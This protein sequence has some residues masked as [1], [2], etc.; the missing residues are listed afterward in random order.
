M[1]FQPG[2]ILL[3]K[4]RIDRFIGAGAF[5][6][7][8]QATHL[9][10]NAVYA[11]KVLRRDGPGLGSSEYGRWVER[12]RQEAK[13]G[14]SLKSAHIVQVYD[15]EEED[16]LLVLRM[17]YLPGGSLA[18]RLSRLKDQGQQLAVE[19]AVRITL[20]VAQGLA[21]LHD[22]DV[23]HRDVK[24]SNILFA[25]D[26]R[27]L[28]ADLGLAQMP[29]G[30]SDRHLL[31]AVDVAS[32]P[33]TPE[34]KSP[35]QVA[36]VDHLTS[37]S[38]VYT[39]GVVLFE[40][41]TGRLYRNVR[42]GT[43]VQALRPD[44]SDW[45]AELL[46]RMLA[47]DYKARSWDGNEVAEALRTGLA[48]ESR[49]QEQKAARHA[50]RERQ[51]RAAEEEAQQAAA[52][53]AEAQKAEAEQRQY[54]AAAARV[55][56][57]QAADRARVA[58]PVR[59]RWPLWAALALV[60]VVGV[61]LVRYLP[62]GTGAAMPTP[63]ETAVV[64]VVTEPP[65]AMA[66]KATTASLSASA[67]TASGMIEA[68]SGQ[69][70]KMVL[71]PKFLGILPF[72]E[73]HQGAE[74]A[75]K[76]L[77]NPTKLEYL[78]PT[79]ENMVAGQIEIV[80]TATTQGVGAVMLNNNAGD[81]IAPAAQAALDKGVTVV[82]WY[83]PIPSGEGE[84][85]FVAQV[86]FNDMGK[87]MADMALDILGADGGKFVVL[88]ASPDAANQNAWIAAMKEALKDP[89][90]AKLQLVDTVYGNDQSEESYKQAL[91]LI[92]K[93]P[94]LKL[95]MA[96]T[97]VGIVAAAKAM[98]DEGLCDTV[99]V[100]GLGLPSEMA[101]YIKAGCAPEI[102][103]WSFVDL[104]YLTYYVS[105]LIATG[106][107]EAKEGVTFKAGRM[108]EYTIEKDPTRANG[109]RVLMGPFTI[110]NKDNIDAAVGP[111]TGEAKVIKAEPGKATKMVLL[112][113]FLGI[114]A[115]DQAHQGAEEAA[116]ELGNPTKLE[117]LG[118][119]PENSVAGQIEIVTNATTQGAQAIMISN[120]AGDQIVPSV[121]A[122]RD[123][124]VS[125]VTWDSP[126]PSGEGEQV[127]VAQVDF[128][129]M[130][131]TMA[132]MA[133]DIMGPDGGNFAVL[134]A[135]PDAANQNAWIAAMK[136]ALKDPKY[137]KLKLIMAPTSV[138]IVA[139][140]KAMQDEGLCDKVK[141]SGL[142]LPSEM[143]LYIKAG[144]APEIALWSF[145]DLGYLTYYVS[146]LIANGQLKGEV[147]ERFEAGRMGTYTIEK[148]P[149]RANGLRVLMGPFRIYNKDN[150]DA[151]SK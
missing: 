94:D 134:S 116:K 79:T 104:G 50:E 62:P 85:V 114:L 13:L 74:E 115:F 1:L 109:L 112:P 96:P 106:Q 43:T 136:E 132:D 36:S 81:Q 16:D 117:F 71:L 69:A 72:D 102:A 77:G 148:D 59:Q 118:P 31:S 127:F 80:T 91:G 68:K 35:E 49:R 97:S 119:T 75:A 131:K 121:K 26:G 17:E 55:G 33:G 63:A 84:Q 73:A 126:I 141:V 23:V 15:Y 20:D 110:Y 139:A 6:E 113:K 137:A 67:S 123:K 53:K 89:K 98:Q 107:M 11:L 12:F 61:I 93:Y 147:G 86:D 83:S 142:G 66:P 95:I 29:G 3:G 51:Q 34:Y 38:D 78:G 138:G 135:S 40:M 14:A 4:Y 22:K 143:D 28:V 60:A 140:A 44:T 124:G 9:R 145:V 2:D 103:L 105:Y 18:D 19:E 151:S 48:V 87:T 8:Y 5:A 130:G 111:L 82:T 146:Y 129:E 21:A 56:A 108:D 24:P 133:L 92:D 57:E 7:V 42:P 46:G 128:N 100:S 65:P 99:K 52:R 45:L 30:S 47:G 32:Q 76:E 37:A 39:L 25:A 122:A 149:T 70:V 64:V 120:N 125:V 101:S 27:A 144:C 58:R 10:L 54:Q 41:L 88:S 150:I 90:Y